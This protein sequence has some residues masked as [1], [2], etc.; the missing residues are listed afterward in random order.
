MRLYPSPCSLPLLFFATLTPKAQTG[1]ITGRV[2]TEDGTAVPNAEIYL[3]PSAGNVRQLSRDS[4]Y[5]TFTDEDGKFKFTR[6]AP[7]R[8]SIIVNMQGY[9]RKP[10][11]ISE[12]Q[13]LIY[14]Y[15]GDKV[16]ITMVKGGVITGKVTNATGEPL[17][18]ARVNAVMVRDA[19]GSPSPGGGGQ[20]TTDDRGV[21]RYY[22]LTPG[23]YILFTRND[24]SVP[25]SMSGDV[26][27]PTYHPSSTRDTA[28]EVAVV[29]GA[30]VTG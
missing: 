17:I 8:Y 18:G 7:I 27:V 3:I 29:S 19:E 28:A 26:D 25:Y 13:N 4:Q 6:L 5:R 16:T 10:I 14:H 12:N 15:A 9:V 30:E 21:Y 23:T 20:R 11:P 24:V 22:G 2:V 1:E